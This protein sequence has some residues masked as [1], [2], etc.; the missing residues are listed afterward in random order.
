MSCLDICPSVPGRLASQHGQDV[1][2]YEEQGKRDS[3][4]AEGSC[5]RDLCTLK[6]LYLA[7]SSVIR[8]HLCLVSRFISSACTG[9]RRWQHLAQ[10][11]GQDS[12]FLCLRRC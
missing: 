9:Q 7:L 10:A 5:E 2:A 6:H 1:Q 4:D 11:H 12:C 8:G 3:D